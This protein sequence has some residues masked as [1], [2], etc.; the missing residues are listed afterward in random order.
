MVG[1]HC[2]SDQLDQAL[3][4]DRGLVELARQVWSGWRGRGGV[5]GVVYLARHRSGFLPGNVGHVQ[6]IRVEI[7]KQSAREAIGK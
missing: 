4:R 2:R 6:K 1:S 7:E 5:V 3:S